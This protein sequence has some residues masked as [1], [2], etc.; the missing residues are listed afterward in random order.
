MSIEIRLNGEARQ[1]P[2]P[3]SIAELLDHLNLPK[4]YVAVE[5][6]RSI[7]PKQ[8]WETVALVQGDEL[9]VVRSEAG[10]AGHRQYL[11]CLLQKE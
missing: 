1:I 2:A 11:A 10:D 5:R 4:E 3:L 9:E 6:N 8:K 7:V